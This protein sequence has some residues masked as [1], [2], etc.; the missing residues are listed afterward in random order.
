MTGKRWLVLFRS[1]RFPNGTISEER[2]I[3][4]VGDLNSAAY[5]SWKVAGTYT[6]QAA[7][8]RTPTVMPNYPNSDSYVIENGYNWT[9]GEWVEAVAPSQIASSDFG[10]LTYHYS[11]LFSCA[12]QSDCP[13]S[14][15]RSR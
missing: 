9:S 1:L 4:V 6:T 14:I 10:F 7:I 2:V 13:T 3:D 5:T 12:Q 8:V 11:D 15:G